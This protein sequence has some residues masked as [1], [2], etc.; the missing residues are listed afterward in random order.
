MKRKTMKVVTTPE[1]HAALRAAAEEESVPLNQ[2][3]LYLLSLAVSDSIQVED[4]FE[5]LFDGSPLPECAPEE[6]RPSKVIDLMDALANSVERAK[7]EREC[8]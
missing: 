6:P 8:Q 1:H 2:Y 7:R 5:H 4:G 3:V